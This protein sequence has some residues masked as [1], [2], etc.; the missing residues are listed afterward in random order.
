M[1]R[2]LEKY[3]E[4]TVIVASLVTI[5]ITVFADVIARFAF[6]TSIVVANEIARL[7][8]VYLIYFGISYAIREH[9]HMRVTFFVDKFPSQFKRLILFVSESIFLV[10]SVTVCVLGVEITQQAIARGKTLSATQWPTSILYAAI[11]FSGLLCSLRLLYSLY[12]IGVKG[13]ISLYQNEEMP[14]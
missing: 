13:D 6:S 9:R 2:F 10:Y 8:F 1:F 3:F 7:C 11:I 14:Q 4:P 5:I 12:Q